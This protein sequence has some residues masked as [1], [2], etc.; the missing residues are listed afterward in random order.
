MN[1]R[2]AP[3]VRSAVLAVFAASLLGGCSTYQVSKYAIAVDNANAFK[4]TGTVK[5]KVAPF[6]A[7]GDAAKPEM[8]C[9]AVGPIKTPAGETFAAY[10]QGALTDELKVAGLYDES[11]PVTIQGNLSKLGFSSGLTD[12]NWQ[13]TLVVTVGDGDPFTVDR[14]YSF[15]SSFIGE[16]A[17]ALSSQAFLPAVQDLMGA[18]AKDPAFKKGMSPAQASAGNS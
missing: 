14:K 9:R 17:C 11:S 10:V 3:R 7:E 5:V 1:A 2:I 6:T 16:K 12:G 4:A 8:S 15:D 18:V 13:L